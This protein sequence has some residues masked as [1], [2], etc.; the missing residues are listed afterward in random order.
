MW[1]WIWTALAVA[2][3]AAGFL[4]WR[5]VWR[6]LRAVGREAGHAAGRLAGTWESLAERT[7]AR[8]AAAPSTAPTLLEPRDVLRARVASLR[9]ARDVRRAWRRRPRPELWARWVSVWR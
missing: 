5:R 4:V 2:S 3:L 7:D 9:A 1:F 8:I 6:Q